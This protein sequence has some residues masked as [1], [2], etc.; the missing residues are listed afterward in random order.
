MLSFSYFYKL[1]SMKNNNWFTDWFNTPYYHLLYKDRNDAEAQLFMR[2]IVQFLNIDADAT[3]AD[4]PCGKGRHSIY[5]NSLGF[6]VTGFDL[7]K[8]SIESVSKYANQNLRFLVHDMRNQLPNQFDVIFNLFTSFGYFETLEDEIK[9][10]TNFKNAL[11][12]QGK[13]VF[14]FLNTTEVAANLV[15]NELKVVENIPF[16]IQREIN[17]NYIIKKIDF[18]ADAKKH[19]YQERVKFLDKNCM[20]HLFEKAGFEI[21]NIFGDYNL[22]DF[23]DQT[24]K[25]LIIIA[26]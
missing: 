26:K 16:F 12:N 11:K 7:S 25:R 10:L 24:S 13:F 22:N 19:T 17:A 9:V 23:N 3:I 1:I 2:N 4:I 15:A 21:C 20:E 5:L 18:V 14:D 8:N 6:D